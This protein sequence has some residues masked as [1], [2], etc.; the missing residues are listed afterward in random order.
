MEVAPVNDFEMMVNFTKI[1]LYLVFMG[2]LIY[3]FS[4]N[5]KIK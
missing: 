4:K 2:I 1:F 3:A 5:P